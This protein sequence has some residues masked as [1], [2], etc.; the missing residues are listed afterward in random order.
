MEQMNMLRSEITSYLERSNCSLQ[1]FSK[2]TGLNKGTLSAILRYRDPKPLS[3]KALD[4]I[5]EAMGHPA[6]WLYPLYL[7]E[8]LI[9]QK[10]KLS[11]VKAYLL[12]CARLG[13]TDCITAALPLILDDLSSI[14]V[15][16]AAGEELY[17][18]GEMEQAALFYEAVAESE[19]FQHS[20]RLAVSH[21]RLFHIHTET[22]Q[23]ES[24]RAAIRFDPFRKRLPEDDQLDALLQLINVYYSLNQWERVLELTDELSSFTTSIYTYDYDRQAYDENERKTKYPLVVY[25]GYAY[26]MKAAVYDKLKKYAEAKRFT[27]K[28]ADLSWFKGLGPAGWQEVDRFKTWAKANMLAYELMLGKADI[29]WE[30]IRHIEHDPDE[31]L[32]ALEKI[33][34]AANEFNLD[35]DLILHYFKGQIESYTDSQNVTNSYYHKQFSMERFVNFCYETSLYY[36]QRSNFENGVKFILQSLSSA[37][38]M[39]NKAGFIKCVT[40]FEEYRG[41]IR[42]ENQREYENM[43]K[44]VRKNAENENLFV[45]YA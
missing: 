11:R 39:N 42:V 25:Y 37:I 23:E 10:W 3:L 6:G 26:L 15:I 17:K 45:T 27:E 30:Y 44:G 38:R 36:F 1:D 20:E 40:L 14:P 31:I 8:C 29:M 28:Y 22:D 13:R 7:D 21:Y 16:F 33:M 41:C 35:V 43:I 12:S 9:D 24:L 19:Q 34:G 4:A 32:P 5:T 18:E 2:L